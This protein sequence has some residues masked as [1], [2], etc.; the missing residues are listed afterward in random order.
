MALMSAITGTPLTDI[1]SD[2]HYSAFQFVCTVPLDVV[3]Q[4][5][6]G[7]APATSVYAEI[8]VGSVISGAMADIEQG[9]TILFS[10]TSDYQATETFRTRVRKVSGTTTLYVGENSQTLTTADY[11]TVLNTYEVQEKLRKSLTYADWDIPFR[12]LLPIET[13]LPSAVVLTHGATAYSPTGVPQAMDASATTSFTHLWASSNSNDTLN[14]GG[15]TAN[16][17]FTLEAGAFRWIRYTYTDS[18]SNANFRVI[19]I[20]TVPKD[21]SSVVALGFVGDGGN[22]ADIN[23]D[24]DLGW[25][26]GVPAW[27]GI[28]SLI[29]RTY[30]V[31]ACD[32][33]Y[34]DTRQSIRTNIN[35]VGFLQNER[36][37]ASGDESVGAISQTTFTLEGFGH[38]L[39]RQN[40]APIRITRVTGAATVWN[41]IQNPTPA[42]M[43]TYHISEGS[44]LFYLCSAIIPA[45][46]SDFVGDDLSITAGKA[47]D[48]IRFIAEVI[49]AELQYDCDGKL[50]LC[51][52]L[53]FLDDTA[54]DAAP[55]VATLTIADY[56]TFTDEMDYASTTASLDMTGGAYDSSADEYNIYQAIAPAQARLRE[57]DPLEVV[58]QVLTTDSTA[59][60]ALAEISE[61]AANFFAYNNPTWTRR[62]TL[63]DEWYFLVPDVGSWFKFT[64]VASDTAR[65]R[66]FGTSDRWQLTEISYSTNSGSGRRS[67]TATF[68]HETQSTGAIVRA[69]P[70]ENDSAADIIYFPAIQPPFTGSSLDLTGGEWYDSQDPAAPS[71]PTP[72]DADCENGGFRPKSDEAYKTVRPAFNN[73]L[74]LITVSGSGQITSTGGSDQQRY[75]SQDFAAGAGI[76]T[77]TYGSLGAGGI[78]GAKNPSSNVRTATADYVFSSP[79]TIY[80]SR[81]TVTRS[82]TRFN[83]SNDFSSVRGY[84]DT[85]F[86]TQVYFNGGGFQPDGEVVVCDNEVDSIQ[87]IRISAGVDGADYPSNSIVINKIEIW[88]G[89]T[90][91]FGTLQALVTDVCNDTPAG[92]EII[93]GDAFYYWSDTIDPTPFNDDE[94]LIVQ[95]FSP[96]SIPP[97]T[98][99]HQYNIEQI[100]EGTVLYL[101]NNPYGTANMTNWSLQFT[102]CFTGIFP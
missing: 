62:V 61:R 68:R 18:N 93:Y 8:T 2:N 74:V 96:N 31:I 85:G 44:T 66:V 58:N 77:V 7:S 37:E 26:A 86:T 33:W 6:P 9:Q 102:T 4:F 45:D 52:N 20:W 67:P 23:Y 32:E 97:Y 40:I 63:K 3:V 75:Y 11:V 21:Y 22:V 100:T 57:G 41:E 60:E 46:D 14:S 55:V 25:T 53:N 34:N 83:G 16:P 89:S 82:G 64:Q 5:Q 76:W 91:P 80:G 15:T 81:I 1:R 48:D 70:I 39:A 36:N 56:E 19:P 51:R 27:S 28:S 69:A 50:E 92:S 29:N 30:T 43:I 101:Y 94:G 24:A 98:P 84:S 35:F 65:A 49:N 13:A 17:S 99:S 73:E 12:K 47:L 38:Q 71:D 88:F 59:T 54:R 87:S 78:V 79:V 72:P 42:R 90:D 95:L 10:T